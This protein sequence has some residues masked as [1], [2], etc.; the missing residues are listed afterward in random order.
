MPIKSLPKN[1]YSDRKASLNPYTAL[2]PTTEI[3]AQSQVYSDFRAHTNTTC[4]S[5][6]QRRMGRLMGADDIHKLPALVVT[7]SFP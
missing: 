3:E 1:E 6:F 5:W 2:K 4:P 7:S